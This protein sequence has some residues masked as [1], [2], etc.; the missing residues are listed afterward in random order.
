[1]TSSEQHTWYILK[2]PDGQCEITQIGAGEGS[3]PGEEEEEKAPIE[4][5]GPFAS[6]DEATARRVGLIRSGKCH[7]V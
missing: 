6:E 1:M 7:P 2:H 3:A 5:W 4:Q